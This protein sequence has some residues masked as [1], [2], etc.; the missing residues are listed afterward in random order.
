MATLVGKEFAAATLKRYQISL[1]HTLAFI[2]YQYGVSDID[3]RKIDH[4]FISALQ[5]C[6]LPQK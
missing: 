4:A 6:K 3:V 5:S 2:N 1:R